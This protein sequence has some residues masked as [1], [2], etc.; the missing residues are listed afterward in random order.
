MAVV[1][2]HTR[3]VKATPAEVGAL[4]DSLAS[5]TDALWP[6]ESWPPMRFDRALGVDASGGHGPIRYRVEAY[7]PGRWIRFRFTGPR[8]F[9]GFHE[10]TVRPAGDGAVLQHLLAMRLH[11]IARLTWPL[12]FRWLHDALIED[13]L[14]HAERA[15]TAISHPGPR[16]NIVVRLLRAALRPAIA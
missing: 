1:N 9:D 6:R 4:V 13:S 11:G 5:E 2:V 12:A 7:V 16:W 14:D 10:Y 3:E 15:G 8:G